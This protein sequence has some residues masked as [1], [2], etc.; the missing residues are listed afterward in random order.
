[1]GHDDGTGTAALT[2]TALGYPR[3]GR[4][5]RLKR[6]LEGYWAGTL[7]DTA[8]AQA[9]DAV[10]R[11]GWRAMTAAGLDSVPVGITSRYD[12]VLD[13]AL[14]VDAVP[15][16]FRGMPTG[17]GRARLDRYSAMARGTSAL[18]PL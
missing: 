12:H 15:E 17:D 2:A 5:R 1:M 6:A 4:D 10:R 11:D 3:I 7:P 9:Q 18:P 14:L 8:V 16:R 13:A